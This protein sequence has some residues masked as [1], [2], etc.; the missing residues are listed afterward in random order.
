[1]NKKILLVFVIAIILN[2]HLLS[3]TEATKSKNEEDKPKTIVELFGRPQVDGNKIVDKNGEV[4][5]LRGM[6][7]FWSQ[8]GGKY[9]N[10]NCIQW[11]RD[12]WKCT[13]IR[14]PLAVESGGYLENP[15]E[16]TTKIRAAVDAC[17]DLGIY[18]IIDW[19]DHNAHL[20]TDKAKLFF[21]QMAILYGDYPNVIYEIYNEPEQVSWTEDVKPYAEQIIAEI[22]AI[23]PDNLIIVGSPMWAQDVDVATLDPIDD[24]NLAYTLHFYAASH[25]QSLRDKAAVALSRE[26]A[27]FVSE[28][29]ICEYTGDGA[30]DETESNAWFN[31]MN[32]LNLSWCKWSVHDKDEGDAV[33]M[34][35][36]D[37]NG[38]WKESDL[39]PS[40]RLIRSELIKLNTPIF[41]LLNN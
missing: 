10:S 5:A 15:L 12:D 2:L 31:F 33:L 16:E 17:I 19:H 36:G 40:G 11:L 20:H 22:R 32:N 41:D 28:F 7:L 21:K 39:K 27:L 14:V 6:S 13:I 34:G 24:P 4:M 26:Y 1:M 8:W 23:D 29:G 25:K 37:V 30:I 18:V 9:F 3:C 38:G 35:P